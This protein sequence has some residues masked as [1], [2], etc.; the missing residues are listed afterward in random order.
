VQRVID[1]RQAWEEPR[2]LIRLALSSVPLA[3]GGVK[4]LVSLLESHPGATPVV[5][6]VSLP[7]EE[8]T[9]RAARHTVKLSDRLLADLEELLGPRAVRITRNGVI[10]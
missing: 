2:L 6:T 8:V 5:M 9:V 3:N 4:S 7:Q 10:D 1:I